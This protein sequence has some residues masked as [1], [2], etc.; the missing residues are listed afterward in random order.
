MGQLKIKID[1]FVKLVGETNDPNTCLTPDVLASQ[2]VLIGGGPK[3]I[4]RK[5]ATKRGILITDADGNASF[6][7]VPE[8]VAGQNKLLATDSNGNLIWI[9][10]HGGA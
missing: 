6:I 7:E 10:Q 3:V 8:G 5:L 2:C 9:D 4:A 1:D